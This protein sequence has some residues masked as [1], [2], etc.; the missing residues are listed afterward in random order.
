MEK[1]IQMEIDLIDVMSWG[2][3]QDFDMSDTAVQDAIIAICASNSLEHLRTEVKKSMRLM[4]KGH[5]PP[6]WDKLRIVQDYVKHMEA[7]K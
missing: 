6:K 2:E 4:M 7:S 3:Q 5:L 1:V